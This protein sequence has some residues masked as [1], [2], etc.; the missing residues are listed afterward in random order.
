MRVRC[1]LLMSGLPQIPKVELE[2]VADRSAEREGFLTLHR[3]DLVLSTPDEGR[4]APFRYD[5]VDRRAIDA[6]V[7][8][9]HHVE[10]GRLCVYLRS[11]VRPPAALRRD[12]PRGSG[13]LW[14][15]PA[16][17]I[18]PGE[19]PSAA[20]VR[21]L[22][23]ELG[24]TLRPE[25]MQPLGAWMFPAPAFIAEV[26]WFFHARVDPT[27]IRPPSGDGSPLEEGA[28]IVSVPLDDA[29]EACRRGEIHDTKTEL[30]LRRL[31]EL[32]L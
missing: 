15:L 3:L 16:G 5:M 11:S 2:V 17:L 18:E 23:E 31:A 8:V 26:H 30:A 24:F 10:Q 14:E 13:V 19:S 7:M 20:A 32:S 1:G 25:D 6:C 9:A 27:T 4:S 22:E 28:R 21:E 29:L 12:E